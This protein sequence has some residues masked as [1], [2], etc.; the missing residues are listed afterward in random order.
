M[1][2]ISLIEK[3]NYYSVYEQNGF[4]CGLISKKANVINY[5][6]TKKEIRSEE[7]RF[8]S[9]ILSVSVSKI[10]FLDQEHKD[11]II[12]IHNDSAENEYCA[13]IADAMITDVPLQI[14]VI[15]TADCVPILLLDNKKRIIAAVH[16]GWRSSF[17]GIAG[18]TVE[19]MIEKGSD[20]GDIAAFIL[21]SISADNYQVGGEFTEK[22]PDS[23]IMKDNNVYLDLW[24]AVERSLLNFGVRNSNIFNSRICSFGDARFFS[25]RRGDSGR[26][27][28]YIMLAE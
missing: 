23:I 8:L 18:K 9:E 25:H 1:K 19:K 22:F 14:L 2:K 7:Y 12:T 5:S 28:N 17:L 27:L 3:D 13:G 16:S 6:K 11:N 21:P 15:R 26:T 20:P 24:D 4:V 10:H